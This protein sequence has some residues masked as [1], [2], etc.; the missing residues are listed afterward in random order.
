MKG[1]L[2]QTLVSTLLWSFDIAWRAKYPYNL[3]TKAAF[4]R[5]GIFHDSYILELRRTFI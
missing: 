3:G 5:N 4:I 2:S 1:E